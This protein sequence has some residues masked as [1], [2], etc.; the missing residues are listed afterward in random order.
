MAFQIF[1]LHGTVKPESLYWKIFPSCFAEIVMFL[2]NFMKYVIVY[3]GAEVPG[4]Y[5]E[6]LR[7]QIKIRSKPF[8]YDILK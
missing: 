5:L 2:D 7:K 4:M 6:L 1:L 3:C 8:F